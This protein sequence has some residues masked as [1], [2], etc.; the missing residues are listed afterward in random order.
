[1]LC[2]LD[3]DRQAS[4]LTML[5]RLQARTGLTILYLSV[6]LAPISIVVRA[7]KS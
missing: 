4:V 1:M 2:G 7:P 3:I 5:Q 6:D